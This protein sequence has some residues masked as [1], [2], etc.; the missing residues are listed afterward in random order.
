MKF[1]RIT[2]RDFANLFGTDLKTINS[3]CGPEIRRSSLAYRNLNSRER[4]AVILN[5]LKKINSV[6]IPISG[7]A[8]KKRWREGW[9]ENLKSFKKNKYDSTELVPKFIR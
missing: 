9:R 2:A 5:I 8:N 7:H 3:F 1:K 4:D 6:D